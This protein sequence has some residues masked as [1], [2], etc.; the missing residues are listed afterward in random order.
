MTI[1][2]LEQGHNY[3]FRHTCRCLKFI[4]M[5]WRFFFP[6]SFLYYTLIYWK[7]QVPWRRLFYIQPQ[8]DD[9][10]FDAGEKL[11]G[12][13]YPQMVEVLHGNMAFYVT[14]MLFVVYPYI[15]SIATSSRDIILCL[16]PKWRSQFRGQCIKKYISTLADNWSLSL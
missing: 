12:L 14:T 4:L 11:Q 6:A 13:T 7:S 8:N 16:T 9:S 2:I 1:Q 10:N 15:F 3:R 5:V